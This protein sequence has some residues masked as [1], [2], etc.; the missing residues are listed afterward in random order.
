MMRDANLKIPPIPDGA[1]I[2]K[3]P[4][5][6]DLIRLAAGQD[7]ENAAAVIGRFPDSVSRRCLALPPNTAPT[8]S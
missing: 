5:G 3:N 1:R 4:R 8:S 7:I 6:G 2:I